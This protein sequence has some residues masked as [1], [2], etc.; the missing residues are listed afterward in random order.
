MNSPAI[1][2]T[3]ELGRSTAASIGD[4]AA[5]TL[6][7][8][9][10]LAHLNL[11]TVKTTLAEQQQIADEAITTRSLEWAMTLPSAQT[12]AAFKK[13]LA[14]WHHVSN[15]V[16]ETGSDNVGYGWRSLNG[17]SQWAASMLDE[18]TRNHSGSGSA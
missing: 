3:G 4:I 18:V 7:G 6:E 16:V 12:Q 8:L 9:E 13:V 1:E 10:R 14:Y 5:R 15:I 2:A 11:Q 17:Y